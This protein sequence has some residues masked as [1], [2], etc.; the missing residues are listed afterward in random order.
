MALRL[1][2]HRHRV[3]IVGGGVAAL[4]AALALHELAPESTSC[5]LVAPNAE[6]VVR[7]QTVRTPFSFPD[8]DRHAVAPIARA[9]GAT[10][11]VDA[12]R[13]VDTNARTIVTVRDQVVPY[14]SLILALGAMPRER[15]P[16]ALTV[17]SHSIDTV[18]AGVLADI[19]AG[20][21][22]DLAFV[23]PAGPTWPL[24]N[25]ELAYMTARRARERGVRLRTTVVTAEDQPLSL[26]GAAA[27][28]ELARLL[29]DGGVTVMT[30]CEA[31]VP[32]GHEVIISPG[33]RRLRVDRVLAL[34]SCSAHPSWASR[35]IATGSCRSTRSDASTA[36]PMSTPPAT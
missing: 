23:T 9:A 33:E 15:Y 17:N 25:Y 22:R 32:S 34:P 3:V 4:E 2:R 30:S 13:R 26:F 1:H 31:E 19:D 24:P 28:R 7:A 20:R 10:L 29:T 6:Y 27:S 5:T 11:L 16:Y 14:D 36:S 35:P 12:L 21:V 18:L 8:A